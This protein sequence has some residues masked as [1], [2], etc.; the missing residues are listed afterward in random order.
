MSS[1]E[2]NIRVRLATP[3]D[4]PRLCELLGVLFSQEADF[5][6]DAGKQQRGLKMI[7]E[8]GEAGRIYCAEEDGVV[9]GM[10]SI[11]FTVSTAEGGRAGLLEDM[12]VDPRRRGKGIGERLLAEAIRGARECGCLRLTLLTD[13][14]NEGA[15][16]FYGR[17]GFVRSGMAPLRLRV[18][19]IDDWGEGIDDC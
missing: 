16:R 5:V 2:S 17:K 19:T 1:D 6:A 14:S 18:G 4:V 11:L 15:M 3:E 12:V 13:S 7:L 9:V 8:K 10:V